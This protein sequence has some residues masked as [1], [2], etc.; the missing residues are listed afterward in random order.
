MKLIRESLNEENLDFEKFYQDDPHKDDDFEKSYKER[1]ESVRNGIVLSDY[2]HIADFMR[3]IEEKDKNHLSV[4][5]IIESNED[6]IKKLF[7]EVGLS[8]RDVAME[9]YNMH[10]SK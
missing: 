10:K 1:D 5:E 2:I 3:R 9:L 6:Y 8:H 7:V 4:P